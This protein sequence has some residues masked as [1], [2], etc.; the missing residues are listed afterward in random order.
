MYFGTAWNDDAGAGAGPSGGLASWGPLSSEVIVLAGDGV[1]VWWAD[2]AWSAW[3][4]WSF[5]RNRCSSSSAR[6]VSRARAAAAGER[7]G[8]RTD[9]VLHLLVELAR[10]RVARLG[11]EDGDWAGGGAGAGARVSAQRS[12]IDRNLIRRSTH[13]RRMCTLGGLGRRRPRRRARRRRHGSGRRSSSRGAL[14]H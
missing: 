6:A 1:C 7:E 4:A 11:I 8:R 14:H 5:S 2:W 13:L 3:S 12:W 9:L 10:D